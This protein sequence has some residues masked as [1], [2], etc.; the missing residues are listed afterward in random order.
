MIVVICGPGGVG[1]GT[2]VGRLVASDPRL[3]LSRSWTTRH[4][5]PGEEADAYTFVTR[6]E[7][8]AR[9]RAGGFLEWAEFLGHL[10]GT[11]LPDPPPGRNLLLEIDVQGAVQIRDR[12]PDALIILVVPP[13]PAAQAARLRGR[14]EPEEQ[15]AR[16]LAAG[17]DEVA[18]G[19][20][21]ADHV[22]VNDDLDR[23][24][25]EVAGIL[26][27]HRARLAEGS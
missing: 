21:L 1:K 14:G 15:V 3:W 6:D 12:F 19:R 27:D 22:V 18:R 8:E 10:Y 5:R 13:S 25:Q 7:F 23:A 11:P 16:R 9:A 4:R 26:D 20:R 2:I 17:A 24:V